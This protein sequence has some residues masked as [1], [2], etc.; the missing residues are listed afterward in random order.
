MYLPS[1]AVRTL[2]YTLNALAGTLLLRQLL[3]KE[4][5]GVGQNLFHVENSPVEL[6]Q[7]VIL[8]CCYQCHPWSSLSAWPQL[9][10]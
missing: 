7:L 10:S 8:A 5:L 4:E 6:L 2:F 3:L 1:F 9:P